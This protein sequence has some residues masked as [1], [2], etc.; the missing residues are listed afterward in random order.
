[1][2]KVRLDRNPEAAPA[3]FN[4]RDVKLIKDKKIT[5]NKSEIAALKEIEG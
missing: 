3:V 2:L 4:R 1:M 5:V